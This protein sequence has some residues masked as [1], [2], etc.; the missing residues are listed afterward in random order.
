MQI[1]DLTEAANFLLMNPEVLR[2]KA[3]LGNVPGRK[4]GKKWVFIKEHL[5]DWV[6]GRYPDR[7]QSLRVI[8]GGLTKNEVSEVC[9]FTNVKIRG[10]YK[11]PQQTASEYN[12][13]LGLK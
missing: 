9:Q 4:A 5:A 13:L 7:G 2:R 11:L 8:D 6:S 1:L 12:A 10:G 3:Y